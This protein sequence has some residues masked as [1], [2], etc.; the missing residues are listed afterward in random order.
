MSS[1]RVSYKFLITLGL[2]LFLTD[3][4]VEK[5]T[6][7]TRF[8][9]GLTSRF[10]IYF[11]GYE[12]FK[13][14]VLKID[15]G[16][17]DDFSELLR[18]FEN[19][20]PST[21]SLCSSNMETAI[22]KA[23]KLISLKSITAKPDFDSKKELSEKEK[24][25]L[26]QKEFNE[27]VDDSYFLIAKARFFKHEFNDAASVFSY[28]IA[29]ANDPEIKTE[30]SIWLARINSETGSYI[31]ANRLLNEIELD[32]KS[33]RE[34]RALYS[35]TLADLF[36]RQKKYQEAIDPLSNSLK[37]ISGKRAR[38][39]FT[40][41]L[42]QLYERTGDPEK[43]I[44]LY[45][46]VVKMNPPYDVEF[47]ARIN[48]AGVFD[49]N[50]GNPEDIR[51]DLEKML[52][53]SKNKDFQDQIYYALGNMMKKE[54]KEK[55]ALEY[56]R[57]SASSSSLNQ[58]QKG[59]SYLA[60]A[61]HYYSIP[62]YMNAGKFYDSTVYFLDEKYP[63]Y[64][65]L[66]T[67]SQNLSSLVTHLTVIQT[68][69]SLQ[70]VAAMSQNE[71]DALISGI[72]DKI[73]KAE[74]EG[75]TSEYADRAN[76]GQYYENERRFQDNI[77][78]EG[79]W[80][81]Y[82]QTAL[83]FGRTEFRRKWGERRLEDN[84]RR[85]NKARV[86]VQQVT[87]GQDENGKAKSDTS[88]AVMDYKKPEFYLK[89]LPLNDTLLKIS[90]EKIANAY[91][92]AGKVFA[93]KIADPQKA[94]ESYESLLSRYPNNELVP[95]TL[96][97]LYKLYK[98]E[99]SQKSEI[100]RQRLL[101]KYPESEFAKIISDPDYYNKKIAEM[102]MSEKLYQEAYNFYIIENFRESIAVCDSA[103]KNNP[104]DNLA[105][106][107]M[108]LR[109]YS[110]ARTS[111]E[112]SFKEELTRLIKAWPATEEGKKAAEISAYLNK[113]LPELK[114]EE[115]K[116]I[117]AELY[118]ADTTALYSFIV[119]L[120]DPSFNI[121]QASF[122]VISYNIDNYTNKNYRTDGILVDN[123]YIKITVSGF[124]NNTQ[125]WDYYNSFKAEKAIRNT[126]GAQIMTFLI[127]SNN[128]KNLDGDKNPERYYLF[129]KE[130]YL[131]GKKNR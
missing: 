92:N 111:D 96:Y 3:C 61:E 24:A 57:K 113:K 13:E 39:R 36:I 23:S 38:Y 20:D 100:S 125:A 47:N 44:S 79:K 62:D 22:Q 102:R 46:D 25:L 51:K 78:Q 68:E 1:G 6:G 63:D 109:A 67:K 70:K 86:S 37:L 75:K 110:V 33:P 72:I 121:N 117:A 108:L 9:H 65:D 69:D 43:A 98:E 120:M 35:T 12:S 29:E 74:S 107:F 97:D 49:V 93:E 130:N 114:I 95:E 119:I 127:N 88:K 81:F 90:N 50:S 45:R 123:K 94:A 91:F 99:N 17:K 101:E 59:K 4:S 106:K 89:N 82:N 124:A 104:S 15:K 31:E 103:I 27:W 19:S 83:T 84:W 64:K 28:C 11:N 71:R 77:A 85:S 126:S 53:D 10:N 26:E 14:G 52:K 118:I 122:D 60:L 5:N 55:E 80:Y 56:Y 2:L 112:R 42:A 41:L 73:I 131:T 129:F 105:P 115:D 58:N 32:P 16:Y 87:T 30:S 7:T 18:V 40:Y 128:T 116:V 21:V 34:L 8:Y 54:G 66:K 76:I 48:I